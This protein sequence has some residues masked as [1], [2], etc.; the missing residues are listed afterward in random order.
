MILYSPSTNALSQK[1]KK[2]FLNN[3]SSFK[4]MNGSHVEWETHIGE[5]NQIE[6]LLDVGDHK[7]I[8]VNWT[9]FVL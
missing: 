6:S 1:K 7:F 3:Y 9:F 8:I 5:P 4:L 2:N